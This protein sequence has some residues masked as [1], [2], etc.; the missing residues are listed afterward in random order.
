MNNQAM[1][2]NDQAMI[3]DK[4]VEQGSKAGATKPLPESEAMITPNPQPE[5]PMIKEVTEQKTMITSN[6]RPHLGTKKDRA[7]NQ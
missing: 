3:T 4:K 6:R 5:D 2:T 7:T 1:I